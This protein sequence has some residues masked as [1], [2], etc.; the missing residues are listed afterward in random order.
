MNTK[1]KTVLVYGAAGLLVAS[2]YG[3]SLYR[4]EQMRTAQG[5]H[6]GCSHALCLAQGASFAAL[7]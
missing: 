6:G 3:A 1:T 4:V 5:A 7:R 2:L